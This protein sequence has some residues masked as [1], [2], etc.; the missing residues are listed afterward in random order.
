MASIIPIS[1][2]H[3]IISVELSKDRPTVRLI[4]EILVV[5]LL[6][7]NSSVRHSIM[8]C[9]RSRA[10]MSLMWRVVIFQKLASSTR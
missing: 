5:E 7:G 2:R 10:S 6:I 9:K 4:R 8:V 1:C 3:W